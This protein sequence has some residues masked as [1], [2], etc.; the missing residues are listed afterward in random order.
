[1]ASNVDLVRSWMQAVND[2]AMDIT[3]ASAHPE[4]ETS[5]ASDLPGA[6]HLSGIDELRSY[7]YRWRKLV[8]VE[9]ARGE[10]PR[11]AARSRIGRCGIAAALIARRDLG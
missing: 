1:M 2:D 4:I 6:A 11:P 3:L 5:E 10:D 8:R 7:G 9:L